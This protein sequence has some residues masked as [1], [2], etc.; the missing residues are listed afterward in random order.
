MKALVRKATFALGFILIAL[1][2][3]TVVP[4]P[5]SAQTVTVQSGDTSSEIASAYGLSLDEFAVLNPHLSDLSLIYPGQVVHVSANA[6]SASERTPGVRRARQSRAARQTLPMETVSTQRVSGSSLGESIVAEARQYTNTPYA[7]GGI[8]SCLPYEI[9]DCSCLTMT[10]YQQFGISMTDSPTKQMTYG[11]AVVGKPQA[12]DLVGWGDTGNITHIGI[13]TGR[14]TVIDANSYSGIVTETEIDA[15]P[16]YAGAR[17]LVGNSAAVDKPQ[18][19]DTTDQLAESQPADQAV[20]SA[21]NAGSIE[22]IVQEAALAYGVD[23]DYLIDVATCEST[24]D[25]NAVNYEYY[26]NGYPSGLF[27]H[28]SGYW[29]GRAADYGYAGASVF[30]P[31]ANANVTAAMFAD[32]Q[33]Y[34]W[35]CA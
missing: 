14:G 18:P 31:V 19:A 25:P 22:S 15:I 34:Q 10:V 32:G 16:N 33:G 9:M 13:A 29:P 6:R 12:G 26:D 11:T 24:L 35:A 30:D 1:V 27:Q 2:A 21:A 5:A 20:A 3:I 17:R 8:G 28:L 7:L 23:P 4:S